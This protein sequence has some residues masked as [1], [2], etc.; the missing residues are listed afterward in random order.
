MKQYLL[1]HEVS[2]KNIYFEGRS[3]NTFESCRNSLR[4]IKKIG[5]EQVVVCTSPYHQ[6]RSD[7]ILKY[8]GYKNYKIARM[9]ESEIYRAKS[10][11]QRFRNLKLIFRDYIAIL[12]F[13]IFKN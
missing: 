6:I 5:F 13:K 7:M 11:K 10:F 1:G 12:K 8:L 3:Q 2:E 9:P 4:I